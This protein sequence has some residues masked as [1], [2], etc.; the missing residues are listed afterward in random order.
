ME[1]TG[2]LG[3]GP[4]PPR[5]DAFI[6]AVGFRVSGPGFRVQGLRFLAVCFND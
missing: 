5:T 6:R 3:E 1:A 4:R 2:F